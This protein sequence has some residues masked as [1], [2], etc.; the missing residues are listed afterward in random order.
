MRKDR[1]SGIFLSQVFFLSTDADSGVIVVCMNDKTIGIRVT[2]D[3][4]LRVEGHR[5]RLQ[6][7][8]GTVQVTISDA[9]RDLVLIGLHAAEKDEQKANQS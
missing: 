5:Q 2:S 6:R 1:T 8:A 7:A 4:L 9:V 3:T